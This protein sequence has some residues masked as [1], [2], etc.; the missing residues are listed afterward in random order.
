MTVFTL[1]ISIDVK[2]G[3]ILGNPKGEHQ[4]VSNISQLEV[5]SRE[6]IATSAQKLALSLLDL[7]FTQEQ[8]AN[9]ICSPICKGSMT[10]EKELLDQRII[11]GIRCKFRP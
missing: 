3:C 1:F 8:L 11:N 10:S 7:F 4:Y 2:E 6:S 5:T 9:A